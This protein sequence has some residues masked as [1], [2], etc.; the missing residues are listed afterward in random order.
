MDEQKRVD[1][2]TGL[3]NITYCD[4]EDLMEWIKNQPTIDVVPRSEIERLQEYYKLY[5][6]RERTIKELQEI[7]EHLQN[8]IAKYEKE[9][10]R[11]AWDLPP[12][13][14]FHDD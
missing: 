2:L 9:I 7:I 14:G 11:S 6:E 5:F 3:N 10:E 1:E 4:Y 8:K 12:M 13:G